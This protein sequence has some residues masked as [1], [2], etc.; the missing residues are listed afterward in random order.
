M[1]ETKIKKK[2]IL[3]GNF[4][5]GKTSLFHQFLYSQFSEK[6]L[7]TIGVK[8]DKKTVEVNGREVVLMIWDIAGEITQDKVP[9]SYFLG[10]SAVIYVFDVKRPSTYQHLSSD[11]EY[12]RNQIPE[13]VVKVVGNKADLATPAEITALQESLNEPVDIFTSA[14]TG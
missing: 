14:K 10:A 12:L 6:Y 13:A 7:T 4:G 1:E 11:L 9:H 3:T 5:V 8:V 2:V